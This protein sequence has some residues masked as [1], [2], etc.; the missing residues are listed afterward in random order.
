MSA[1]GHDLLELEGPTLRQAV[2]AE[3]GITTSGTG[4]L[5][6]STIETM[7]ILPTRASTDVTGGRS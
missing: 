5:T 6:S 1:P 3:F 4:W 2:V 7:A